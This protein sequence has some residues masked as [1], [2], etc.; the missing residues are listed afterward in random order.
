[1]ENR[2]LRQL[3]NDHVSPRPKR[4][5]LAIQYCRRTQKPI[6]GAICAITS[7]GRTLILCRACL[8]NRPPRLARPLRT[9]PP[10]SRGQVD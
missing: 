2:R 7:A 9:G 5:S 6:S 4:A 3:C 1:M 8:H 10:K